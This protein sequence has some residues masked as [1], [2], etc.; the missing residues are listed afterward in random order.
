LLTPRVAK[1]ITGMLAGQENSLA[2]L[3]SLVEEDNP[4]VPEIIKV[5]SSHLG[6][7]YCV[8]ITGS[9]GVGKSTL[10]DKLITH[11]R[12]KGLEWANITWMKEYLFGVWLLEVAMVAF[13]KR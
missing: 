6:K 13:P 4:E 1:L 7:A 5:L 2:Q 11:M 12:G 8:G 3:I 10:V 9:A